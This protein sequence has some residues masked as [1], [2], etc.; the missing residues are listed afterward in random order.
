MTR[1]VSSTRR[2]ETPAR[3]ICTVQRISRPFEQDAVAER[4][5]SIDNIFPDA[6]GVRVSLGGYSRMIRWDAHSCSQSWL[7]V[8]LRIFADFLDFCR[9]FR[10]LWGRGQ[11]NFDVEIL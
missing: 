8:F 5:V 10:K 11:N 1:R 4:N 7:P 9:H 3:Y 6:Q 2:T